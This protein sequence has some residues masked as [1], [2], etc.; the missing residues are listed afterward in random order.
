MPR[1]RRAYYPPGTALVNGLRMKEGDPI[2]EDDP[3]YPR[4]SKRAPIRYPGEV[5]EAGWWLRRICTR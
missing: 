3:L 4:R 2:S 5:A 1:R